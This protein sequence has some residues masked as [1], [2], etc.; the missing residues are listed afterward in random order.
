MTMQSLSPQQ[1][2]AARKLLGWTRNDLATRS[3]L[4]ETTLARLERGRFR[5]S[6]EEGSAYLALE[7]ALE[8]AGIEFSEDGS[9]ARL[10]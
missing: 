1:V 9:I 5:S 10:L 7:A 2:I 8:G 6:R 3:G 4:S